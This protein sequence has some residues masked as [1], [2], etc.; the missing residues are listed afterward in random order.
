MVAKENN[1]KFVEISVAIGHK[2]DELLVGILNQIR[3][4]QLR[5]TK[6]N[7][8]QIFNTHH[9]KCLSKTKLYIRKENALSCLNFSTASKQLWNKFISKN[10]RCSKSVEDL[11]SLTF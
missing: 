4:Q 2:V 7:S 3:Q 9:R 1:C 5:S 11:L 8:N 6:I 10:K